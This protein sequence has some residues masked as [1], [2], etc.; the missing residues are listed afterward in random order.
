[1]SNSSTARLSFGVAFKEEFEFPWSD[2]EKYDDGITNWWKE[3]NDYV[4][5]PE[6]FTFASIYSH[7]SK[8]LELN[9]VPFEIVRSGSY[10]YF[11]SIIATR[12]MI[13]DWG[14]TLEVSPIIF[15]KRKVKDDTKA[16]LDFLKKYSIEHED[17][18]KWLLSSYYG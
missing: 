17:S 13:V 8:W 7:Q 10:E 6:L 5:P 9:P 4:Q 2:R 16:I 1:M 3:V 18:P 11:I 12:T 14:E 15:N